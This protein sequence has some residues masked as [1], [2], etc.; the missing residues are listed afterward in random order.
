MKNTIIQNTFK[1]VLEDV[2][3]A[4]VLTY[5]QDVHSIYVYG[6]V[7]KGTAKIGHSDLDICI[8]F[9]VVKTEQEQQLIE[10]QQKILKKYAFL[11]KIDFDIGYVDEVLL[12]KNELYW[13]AWIKFFCVNIYGKDLSSNFTQVEI[14]PKVIQLINSGYEKEISQYLLTLKHNKKDKIELLNIKNSL[15]KRMIRLLPLTLSQ[16]DITTWPLS[17]EETIKQAIQAHPEQK[18]DILYLNEQLNS[19]NMADS[20]LIKNLTDIYIWIVEHIIE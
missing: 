1:P 3:Q 9:K 11:P 16:L 17:I 8:L 12:E 4:C 6:S 10:I 13:G 2:I 15:I 14:S 18:N 5:H 19:N 7:A 20:I